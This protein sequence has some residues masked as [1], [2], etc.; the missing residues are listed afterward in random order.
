MKLKEIVPEYHSRN[1]FIR[2]LFLGRLR[3]A[4]FLAE[5]KLRSK[6]WLKV[7]DFGCGEGNLLEL[8][9]KGFKNVKTY[10]I[11]AEPNVLEL[12]KTL[13]A[14]IKVVDIR[15][16]GFVNEFFDIVFCLDTLE[17]FE[18]LKKPAMEIKRVLKPD[19]MLIVSLPTE[20]MFYKVGRLLLKGTMSEEKGPCSSPHFH[21][22]KDIRE[23]LAS[24]SFEVLK[25]VQVPSA[26]FPAL[27]QI[28]ALKRVN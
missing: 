28:M 13:R 1:A 17:H 16:S 24:N 2:N 14:E 8:I 22:A 27:F 19:G 12:T 23:F 20:S 18:D 11:D 25:K 21:S 4:L 10:G 15:E 3:A 9:E 6:D 7:A 26:P 5:E